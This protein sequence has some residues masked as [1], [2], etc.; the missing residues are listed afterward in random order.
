M[1]CVNTNEYITNGKCCPITK[2]WDVSSCVDITFTGNDIS[3]CNKVDDNG[4]CIECTSNSGVYIS[5]GRCCVNGKY[6]N[7]TSCVDINI[8]TYPDCN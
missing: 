1:K 2:K 3:S 6:Y 5:N 8:T 7:G 4:N